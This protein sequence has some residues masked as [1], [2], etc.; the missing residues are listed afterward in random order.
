MLGNP[1]L[2]A[3]IFTHLLIAF[4]SAFDVLAAESTIEPAL[5]SGH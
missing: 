4:L 2:A 3:G 1:A 5:F